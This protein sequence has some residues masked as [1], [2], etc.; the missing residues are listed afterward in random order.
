M[1]VSA[2][3]SCASTEGVTRTAAHAASRVVAAPPRP[4]EAKRCMRLSGRGPRRRSAGAE[5]RV[6]DD[7]EEQHVD[8]RLAKDAERP[9][10]RA[11]VDDPPDRGGAHATGTR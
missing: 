8:A 4:E 11:G 10:L 6:E 7:V 2:A 1:A 9:P 3:A 5:R